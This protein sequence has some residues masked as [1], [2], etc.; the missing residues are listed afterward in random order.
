MR[1]YHTPVL[2]QESLSALALKDKGIWVDATFGGGGHSRAILEQMGRES[3]LFS[4]D[5]DSDALLNAPDDSRFTLINN[6]YRFVQ[7]FLN[8]NGVERVDGILAD[9]GL[10]SHQIDREERGFSFRFDSPLDM[11]M[12]SH[13]Q[14]SA[15]EILNSYSQESLSSLLKG[16][17]EV[18][19]SWRVASLICSARERAPLKSSFDL[20]SAIA[21]LTPRHGEYKFLAKVYQAL[22]IEVNGELRALEEL[23]N[24]SIELL[25]SGGRLVIITY[26]SLEDRMVKNFMRSGNSEGKIEKNL[27]GEKLSPFKVITRKPLLPTKEEIENNSRARSAKLRV[28]EKI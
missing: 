10:S 5:R 26:H 25:N 9:L 13:S 6:N 7:N 23:L 4:F 1:S 19:S 15:A 16:Y 24:S 3:K 21:P 20:N 12:S 2:L 22:R 14:M 8:Y 18:E 27:Y 28:A 11:R 17:G